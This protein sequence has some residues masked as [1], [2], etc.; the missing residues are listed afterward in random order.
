MKEILWFEIAQLKLL[1]QGGKCPVSG[2]NIS[3]VQGPKP[4][5]AHRIPAGMHKK[6]GKEIVEHP[7]NKVLVCTFKGKNC[8]D[9]VLLG[10]AQP[11][12]QQALAY[13]ITR[14]IYQNAIDWDLTADLS[15]ILTP[16][17]DMGP[18]YFIERQCELDTREIVTLTYTYERIEA[19]GAGFYY[20]RLD[21]VPLCRD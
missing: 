18:V 9:A 20:E 1:E 21:R 4:E 19:V 15:E 16:R 13:E 8:N 2:H 5:L 17:E 3:L 11:I 14:L 12:L 7:R 10:A 6:Y